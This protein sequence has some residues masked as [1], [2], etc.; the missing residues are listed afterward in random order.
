[1]WVITTF[2]VWSLLNLLTITLTTDVPVHLHLP[3]SYER[4]TAR[5]V[6]RTFRGVRFF[7]GFDW[8]Y[9]IA[10]CIEQIEPGPTLRH[11][12]QWLTDSAFL[13]AYFFFSEACTWA[14]GS[15]TSIPMCIQITARPPLFPLIIAGAI[16]PPPIVPPVAPIATSVAIT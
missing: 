15:R 8:H 12:F 5:P 16:T 7:C 6:Y 9:H 11:T 1:M 14:T 13:T 4:P 2:D 10:S 3:F